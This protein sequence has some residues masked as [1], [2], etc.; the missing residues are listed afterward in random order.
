MPVGHEIRWKGVLLVLL[1]LLLLHLSGIDL[2]EETLAREDGSPDTVMVVP[3]TIP[4]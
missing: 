2:R 1:A 4:E 3:D